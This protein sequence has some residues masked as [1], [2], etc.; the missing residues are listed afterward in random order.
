MLN[1][2]KYPFK[3]SQLDKKTNIVLTINILV[4]VVLNIA[5]TTSN[6]TFHSENGDNLWYIY[7]DGTNLGEEVIKKI[8]QFYLLFN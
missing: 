5:F 8:A 2:G 6:Y 1:S 4:M 7:P 3:M